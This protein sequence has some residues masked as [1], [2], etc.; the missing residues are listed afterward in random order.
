[1]LFDG[2]R[3]ASGGAL[4]PDLSRPGIGL[5]LKRPDAERWRVL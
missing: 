5:E 3:R 2:A 4:A 1:M